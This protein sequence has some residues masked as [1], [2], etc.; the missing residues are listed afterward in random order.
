MGSATRSIFIGGA[1]EVLPYFQM[2]LLEDCQHRP[3]GGVAV[4]LDFVVC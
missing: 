3:F 2:N 4:L 1:V